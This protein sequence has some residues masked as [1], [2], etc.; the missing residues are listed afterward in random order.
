MYGSIN[1]TFQRGKDSALQI[2]IPRDFTVRKQRTI[3]GHHRTFDTTIEWSDRDAE[4][5]WSDREYELFGSSI[6][7]FSHPV[8]VVPAVYVAPVPELGSSAGLVQLSEA[9]RISLF[10]RTFPDPDSGCDN[11]LDE[12]LSASDLELT[13]ADQELPIAGSPG[14]DLPGYVV[15]QCIASCASC[16]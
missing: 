9:C 12:E 10:T 7:I 11:G 1:A 5:G 3:V 8:S 13:I 14:D 4:Q 2:S 15:D 6:P 16:N